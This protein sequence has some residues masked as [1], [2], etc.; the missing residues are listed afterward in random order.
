[1]R[2]SL[3]GSTH[4][5]SERRG[6]KARRVRVA[7]ARTIE[8]EIDPRPLKRQ[9]HAPIGARDQLRLPPITRVVARRHVLSVLG[10]VCERDASGAAKAQRVVASAYPSKRPNAPPQSARHGELC[11]ER[12]RF[13]KAMEKYHKPKTALH[14]YESNAPWRTPQRQTTSAMLS[15]RIALV[16]RL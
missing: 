2:K 1:M 15:G 3:A 14:V 11:G 9:L 4:G 5:E 16:G 12:V 8:P 10:I 13:I 7:R 6:A